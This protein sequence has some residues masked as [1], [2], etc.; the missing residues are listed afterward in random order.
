MKLDSESESGQAGRRLA[1][2][3]TPMKNPG[4]AGRPPR[5]LFTDRQVTIELPNADGT[6]DFNVP[7]R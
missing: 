4:D 6:H 1:P 5:V 3:H 2:R 7:P